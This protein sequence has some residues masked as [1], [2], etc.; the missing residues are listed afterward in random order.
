MEDL[1]RVAIRSEIADRV[2]RARVDLEVAAELA[3]MVRPAAA[4]EELRQAL[5]ELA[6]R[7]QEL[8][9]ILSPRPVGVT[10]P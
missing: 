8:Q 10:E 1:R 7:V 5:L 6:G 9:E 4:A 2:A 3:L